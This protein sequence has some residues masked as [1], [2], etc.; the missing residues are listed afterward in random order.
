MIFY[1]FFI[2]VSI[3]LR[4]LKRERK[5]P[6]IGFSTIAKKKDR[7]SAATR[8]F[9]SQNACGCRT[10]RFFVLLSLFAL[11][12][13]AGGW[14]VPPLRLRIG[15]LLFIIFSMRIPKRERQLGTP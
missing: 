9:C 10:V 15:F 14:E 1:M 11:L 2:I 3:L 8:A 4:I 7:R 5:P 13:V 12:A 6:I